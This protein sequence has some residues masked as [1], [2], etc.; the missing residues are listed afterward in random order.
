M[1]TTTAMR[2]PESEAAPRRRTRPYSSSS[3]ISP[4]LL[5]D[6]SDLQCIEIEGDAIVGVD[7]QH[8]A[9]C[10]VVASPRQRLLRIESCPTSR[11]VEIELRHSEAELQISTLPRDSLN[12]SAKLTVTTW[13]AAPERS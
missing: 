12:V 9:K 8:F 2:A 7:R 1:S 4:K 13:S 3:R 11:C 6:Q 5:A 10:V